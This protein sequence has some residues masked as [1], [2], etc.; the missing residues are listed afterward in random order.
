MAI[1][2]RKSDGKMLAVISVSQALSSRNRL[3]DTSLLALLTEAAQALQRQAFAR[4]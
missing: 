1:S 4:G 3:Q 2:L